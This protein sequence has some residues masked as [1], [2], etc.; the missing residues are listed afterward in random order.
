VA[1]IQVLVRSIV[2]GTAPVMVDRADADMLAPADCSHISLVPAQ[3]TR[4]IQGIDLSTNRGSPGAAALARFQSVLL[5]GAA[6]PAG[7]VAAAREAGIPVTTTYGM[8]ETCGGCVYDGVPL[9]GVSVA[10][11]SDG[12]IR[13]TGPVLFSGY[14]RRP[15]LTAAALQ[16]G[17]FVTSDLGTVDQSGHLL[18]RGR[19]DDVINTGGQKVVAGEVAAVLETCPGVREVVVIGRPDPQWG[20]RVTAVVVPVD[21]ADPPAL[22]LLRKHVQASLPRYAAPSQVELVDVIPLLASGKPDL[23]ALQREQ[24]AA[25]SVT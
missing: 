9:D 25:K 12:R 5:G 20:E 11:G 2:A 14:R 10:T 13:I 4:L 16:D 19:A 6:A 8:T 22:D 17:W 1:G 7:L 24:S 18:V 3:L 23:M 21:P 15:D